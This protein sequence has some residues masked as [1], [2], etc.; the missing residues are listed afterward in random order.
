MPTA[1]E[2]SSAFAA[3]DRDS[4]GTLSAAE[5]I[6]ILTRSSGGAPL[7]EGEAIALI[8]SVD[9][10]GDGEL[11][12]EE[13][14]T[15]MATPGTLTLLPPPAEAEAE[16]LAA[17]DE[18]TRTVKKS[19]PVLAIFKQVAARDA[20]LTE[21]SLSAAAQSEVNMEFS[22][23]PDR[24]KAAGLA[25]LCGS[26][27]ITRINLAGTNLNDTCAR[28]LASAL[29]ASSAAVEILNLERNNLTEVGLL[30]IVSALKRN[31][32]LRELRLTGQTISTAVEL[33]FAE[34]LDSGALPTLTKLS[35]A[36]RNPNERRRVEAALSRNMD[37]LRKKRNAAK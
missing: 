14:C 5:L 9:I 13:F 1:E 3:F 22:M 36:M 35:P 23:W 32:T 15:L 10:N 20:A 29:G 7:A 31:G 16:R 19:S 17:F 18:A 26:P 21:L 25:L 37:L 30:E 11:S 24:R 33:A 28:A 2:L 6:D 4:S 8:E 27:V 12:L 34:L